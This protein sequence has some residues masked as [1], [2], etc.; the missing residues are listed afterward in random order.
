M[1]RHWHQN[2]GVGYYHTTD[3]AYDGYRHEH[4]IHHCRRRQK[5]LRLQRQLMR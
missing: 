5:R 4:V 1:D 3:D 2:P